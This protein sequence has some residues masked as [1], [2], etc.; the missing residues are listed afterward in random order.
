[1]ILPHPATLASAALLFAA[2]IAAWHLAAPQRASARIHL[3]FAAMLLSA[4]AVVSALRLGDV[5]AQFLLPLA[6][7]ALALAALARLARP[8][9]PLLATLFLVAALTGG[10][11]ALLTGMTMLAMLP[12]VIAA[13][14]IVAVALGRMAVL[15]ALAGVALLGAALVFLDHGATA[16]LLLFAAAAV[17]GLARTSAPAIDQAR[18]ARRDAI[19]GQR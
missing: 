11:G 14:A 19:I 1:M 18:H 5:A 12:T 2:C 9:P 6:G 10:L 7:A 13:L 8:A 16:G 15:P 4:L 3:R 17:I